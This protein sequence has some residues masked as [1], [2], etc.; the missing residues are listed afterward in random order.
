MRPYHFY[1]DLCKNVPQRRFEN[2][3]GGPIP[4][5][6]CGEYYV[7]FSTRTDMQGLTPMV[8]QYAVL[9]FLIATAL[10]RQ[11]LSDEQIE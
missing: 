4:L 11:V 3:S 1:V 9:I 7:S 2:G 6:L 8:A 5:L 10:Y